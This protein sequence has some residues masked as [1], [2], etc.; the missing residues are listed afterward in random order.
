MPKAICLGFGLHK[1]DI[2]FDR[3]YG[4][5]NQARTLIW[6]GIVIYMQE[7]PPS[8]VLYNACPLM[9][10]SNLGSDCATV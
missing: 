1:Y 10:Y 4:G 8:C 6:K 3:I 7:P 5:D 9:P 2:V